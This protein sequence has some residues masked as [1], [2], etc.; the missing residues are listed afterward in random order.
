DTQ[1]HHLI[2]GYVPILR[3][4]LAEL[5]ALALKDALHVNKMQD[6]NYASRQ[7]RKAAAEA[8]DA[9]LAGLFGHRDEVEEAQETL[10]RNRGYD[11]STPGTGS[12]NRK[13]TPY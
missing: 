7:A 3:S 5:E 13:Y 8:D 10:R 2:R 9:D 1:G 6:R 4:R 11:S 12:S